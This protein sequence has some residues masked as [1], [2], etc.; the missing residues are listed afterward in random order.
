VRKVE[1]AAHGYP[2]PRKGAPVRVL[3]D[4][5]RESHRRKPKRVVERRYEFLFLEVPAPLPDR[6]PHHPEG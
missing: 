4:Y 5:I 2:A 1:G 6:H 3:G